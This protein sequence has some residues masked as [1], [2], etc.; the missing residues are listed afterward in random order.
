MFY[1]LDGQVSAV[2][3]SHS[4]ALSADARVLP[5]GTAV[6]SGSG[7]TGSLQ[8]V[9]GLD[10]EVE[11]RKFLTQI[12]ERSRISWKE[13][14]LQGAVIEVDE[15]GRATTIETLRV[16]CEEAHHD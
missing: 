15:R 13:L 5:G 12:P 3:G 2:I 6:V 7:R 11:I 1:H 9:G 16:H 14:E 10:P 4:K 8:S